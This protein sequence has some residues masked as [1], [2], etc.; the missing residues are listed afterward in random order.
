MPT[1]IETQEI[2]AFKTV[3]EESGFSKAAEKLHVTQSAVS[4]TISNLEKKLNTLLIERTNPLALTESGM[5]FLNY[6]ELAVKEE[7]NVL[8]DITHIR[9]GIL[10]TLVLALNNTVSRLYANDLLNKYYT[11]NPLT[12]L[13]V[14]VMPSRQIISAVASDLWELGFGPFQ[15]LMPDYFDVMP[16]FEDT[17]K[18]VV[19][20]KHPQLAELQSNPQASIQKV[21]LIVSH[22]DDPDLRPALDK[23]RNTFGTIWEVNDLKLRIKLISQ[24]MGISYLDGKLL[25]DHPDCADFVALAAL[26]FSEIPL[27]F[28][29]FN[30]RGKHLSTGARQFIEICNDYEFK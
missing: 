21:P 27:T 18:L 13:K 3:W 26:P 11:L 5:R 29:L 15:Q 16:L 7:T 9:N 24:G 20:Q 4:Q 14:D 6:A 23:L 8:T 30:R 19:S 10:S 25:D 12:G 1:H 2:R 22:L 17:R 28:G